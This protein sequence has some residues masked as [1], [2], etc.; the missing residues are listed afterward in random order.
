VVL[1]E[2]GADAFECCEG[3]FEWEDFTTEDAE[4]HREPGGP[5]VTSRLDQRPFQDD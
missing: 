4:G 1:F 5:S 3:L 2:C